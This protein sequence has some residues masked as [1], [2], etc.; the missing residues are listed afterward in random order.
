MLELERGAFRA[1]NTA[2][3][4]WRPVRFEPGTRFPVHVHKRPEFIFVLEGELVQAGRRL[5]PGW[6]GSRPPA[7]RTTTSTRRPGASSCWSIAP[8]KLAAAGSAHGAHAPAD[9]TARVQQ[10]ASVGF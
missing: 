5:G 1:V 6:P 2:D 9:A 8:E 4:P 7:A 10:I 3:V